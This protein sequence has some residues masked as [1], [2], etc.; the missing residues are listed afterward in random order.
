LL[1]F[2]R[3]YAWANRRIIETAAELTDDERRH[4]RSRYV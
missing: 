1:T 2:V 4:A 3:F